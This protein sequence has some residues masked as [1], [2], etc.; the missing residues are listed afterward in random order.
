MSRQ[1]NQNKLPPL[2][3]GHIGAVARV[4]LQLQV[5]V[6]VRVLAQVQVDV[7]SLEEAAS[8]EAAWP[9]LALEQVQFSLQTWVSAPDLDE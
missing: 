3:P 9:L 5:L 1:H 4:V 6:R 7:T 2:A 8:W